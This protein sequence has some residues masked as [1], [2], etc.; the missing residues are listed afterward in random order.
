MS[1]SDECPI[2]YATVKEETALI[3]YAYGPICEHYVVCPNKCYD[4]EYAY[5]TTVVYVTIR[6]HVLMFGWSYSDDT[7]RAEW[8]AIELACKAAQKAQLEDY[9]VL[10]KQ[11]GTD[12]A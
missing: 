10:V 7:S 1:S 12:Q 8:D 6:G 9:W 2:C 3:D 4:Y 5:G 11:H